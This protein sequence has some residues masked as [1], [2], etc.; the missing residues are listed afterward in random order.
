MFPAQRF[1]FLRALRFETTE[2]RSYRTYEFTATSFLITPHDGKESSKTKNPL[3]FQVEGFGKQT[4]CLIYFPKPPV[5][6][7][8][9][10]PNDGRV[11]VQP[12][13]SGRCFCITLDM[14]NEFITES[15]L[16]I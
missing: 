4:C 13:N 10:Y 12:L 3:T 14:F 11:H 9:A 16:K 15:Y 1:A 5:S 2:T 7:S 8:I 6:F